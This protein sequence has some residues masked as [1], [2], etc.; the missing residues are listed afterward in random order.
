MPSLATY[1]AVCVNYPISFAPLRVAIKERLS[2]TE[3]LIQ[4]LETLDRWIEEWAEREQ[5]QGGKG[6]E[7]ETE[8]LP[9]LEKV[10]ISSFI[11][12]LLRLRRLCP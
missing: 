5:T 2:D 3:E 10:N 6:S 7:G 12:H 8:D 11:P 1:L 9:A 4:V